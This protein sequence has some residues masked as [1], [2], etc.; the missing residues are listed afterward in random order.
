MK[1]VDY[2]RL[3]AVIKDDAY[4]LPK[5]DELLEKYRTANWFTSLDLAARYHHVEMAKEDK[6]KTVFICSKGLFKYN[7]M[8]FGLKTAPATFQRLM[9]EILEKYIKKFV[10]VYL[11]D[12]M[13][14]LNNFE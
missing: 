5:I 3:N 14:Y 12:I 6:E 9:D 7:V 2:K 11:N 4:R 10:V 13:I 8:P 1:P